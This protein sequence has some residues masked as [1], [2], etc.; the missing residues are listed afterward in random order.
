VQDGSKS[1]DFMVSH[2]ESVASAIGLCLRGNLGSGV[3]LMITNGSYV[4]SLSSLMS[5]VAR[6][7]FQRSMQVH[8]RGRLA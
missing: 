1:R 4:V 5:R 3:E 7:C 8:G 6:E 2:F